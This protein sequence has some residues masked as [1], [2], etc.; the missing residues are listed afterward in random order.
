MT[1]NFILFELDELQFSKYD[2]LFFFGD[3]CTKIFF[4]FDFEELYLYYMFFI[5]VIFVIFGVLG[6]IT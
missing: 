2:V 3:L 1:L 5:V 6:E 4:F